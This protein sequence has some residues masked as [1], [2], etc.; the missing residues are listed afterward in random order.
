MAR[1]RE[2]EKLTYIINIKMIKLNRNEYEGV[3]GELNRTEIFVNS[4]IDYY[5]E[6]YN[7]HRK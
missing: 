4:C 5:W 3:F 7:N 2:E 1:Y 6:G